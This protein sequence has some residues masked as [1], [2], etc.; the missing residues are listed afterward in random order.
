MY[1]YLHKSKC[2]NVNGLLLSLMF[3]ILFLPGIVYADKLKVDKNY[4]SNRWEAFVSKKVSSKFNVVSFTRGEAPK[5]KLNDKLSLS[6]FLPINDSIAI[7]ANKLKLKGKKY[8]MEVEKTQWNAGVN[9]FTPWEVNDFLVPNKISHRNLGISIKS[10]RLVY[11]PPFVYTDSDYYKNNNYRIH[12]YT[13]V[14]IKEFKFIVAENK[15]GI[16][17]EKIVA[18]ISGKKTFSIKFDMNE[19]DDGEYTIKVIAEWKHDPGSITNEYKF[20]HKKWGE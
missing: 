18:H 13:P 14:S 15:S 20:Y 2:M 17:M 3:F 5:Y 10:D 4:Y 9:I 8:V 11:Y 7:G 6:F 1:K 12:F 16:L 19:L